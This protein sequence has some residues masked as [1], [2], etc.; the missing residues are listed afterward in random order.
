MKGN[1]WQLLKLDDCPCQVKEILDEGSKYIQHLTSTR[2][3]DTKDWLCGKILECL[4]ERI[5]SFLNI[6]PSEY[7][8]PRFDQV[9]GSCKKILKSTQP[10]GVIR[11]DVT[12]EHSQKW[13]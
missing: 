9:K 13:V 11:T 12:W 6:M 1:P 10:P 4:A 2:A 8:D 3:K 5:L 7:Y